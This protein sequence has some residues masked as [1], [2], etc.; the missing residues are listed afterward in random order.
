[1]AYRECITKTT[2]IEHTHKKQSGGS[3]QYAKVRPALPRCGRGCGPGPVPARAPG[4]RSNAALPTPHAFLV[5]PPQIKVK[6][7][8]LENGADGFEFVSDIKGGTVPKE[9]IPGVAKASARGAWGQR[10]ERGMWPEGKRAAKRRQEARG[11]GGRVASAQLRQPSP[12][13]ALIPHRLPKPRLRPALALASAPRAPAVS[14]PRR[15]PAS[16][17][18]FIP[19]CL[20]AFAFPPGRAS[21]R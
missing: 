18:Y 16:C 21:S 14:A 6:F 11:A 8:P 9:Y 12:H 17:F 20:F 10:G 19:I 7:E 4:P 5:L 3:G 13:P 15:V 1:M 2:E